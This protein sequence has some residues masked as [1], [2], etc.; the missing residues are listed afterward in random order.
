MLQNLTVSKQNIL[1]VIFWVMVS[2]DPVGEHKC[3][4]GIYG[5]RLQSTLNMK[6]VYS[7]EILKEEYMVI[8]FRVP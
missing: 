7:Y 6:P 5:H 8:V 1:T 2:C 3:L 4:G